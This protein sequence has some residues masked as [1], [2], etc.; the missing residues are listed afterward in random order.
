MT[1]IELACVLSRVI[2]TH[3][4]T[5]DV[6]I[7]EFGLHTYMYTDITLAEYLGGKPLRGALITNAEKMDEYDEQAEQRYAELCGGVIDE[8]N[9]M[10]GVNMSRGISGGISYTVSPGS[11]T[12]RI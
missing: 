6:Y 9:R 3:M 2:D 11:S 1:R 4:T 7:S 5:R 12:A 10:T 8:F